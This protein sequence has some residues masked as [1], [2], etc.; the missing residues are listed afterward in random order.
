MLCLQNL[1]HLTV[2]NGAGMGRAPAAALAFM[3]YCRGMPLEQAFQQLTAVRA[4]NPRVM[5]I[6]QAACDILVD[7]GTRM[8]CCI[9]V[10]RAGTAK[11]VQAS[12]LT[13]MG[14]FSS[15]HGDLMERHLSA[16]VLV[17]A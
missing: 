10:S 1:P 2:H 5:A 11:Q 6:R 7:A 13:A 12:P 17:V 8:K 4:C 14:A 9:S 15:G 3:F 16:S